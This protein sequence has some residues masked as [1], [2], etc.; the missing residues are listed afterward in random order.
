MGATTTTT[1]TGPVSPS[2]DE[3]IAEI[4]ELFTARGWRLRLREENGTW[5]AWFYLVGVGTTLPTSAFAASRLDAAEA[6]WAMYQQRP[7]LN[8]EP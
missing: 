8:R 1:T 5:E 6:A 7:W 3:R 2:A 4:T